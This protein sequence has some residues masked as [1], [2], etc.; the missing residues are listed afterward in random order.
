[1]NTITSPYR[2]PPEGLF[3]F[4]LRNWLHRWLNGAR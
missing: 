3:S 2:Q 4:R 1:M